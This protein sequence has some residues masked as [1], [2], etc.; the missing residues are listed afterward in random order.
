MVYPFYTALLMF[1]LILCVKMLTFTHDSTPV[2]KDSVDY[3]QQINWAYCGVGEDKDVDVF[4][5]APTVTSG[6]DGTMNMSMSDANTKKSFLGATNMEKGIYDVSCRFYAPYYRQASLKAYQLTEDAREE[7]LEIAYKDVSK[8]FLYYMDNLNNGRPYVLA[9][10]SQGADMCIRLMKDY[11]SNEEY[12]NNLVATYAIGWGLSENEVRTYEWLNPAQ[13]E[14]DLGVIILLNAETPEITKTLS[15]QE[16][17]YGINPL[18]WRTD[19]KIAD[20]SL[21][22]GACFTNYEGE[23]SKEIPNFC[24]CYLDTD[25]GTL[26][27]PDVSTKDYPAGLEIFND[28]DFHIYDYMFFYRNLQDNV[29]VRVNRFISTKDLDLAA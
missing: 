12:M 25:R 20:A 23:I 2:S 21:N 28:G 10:F 19:D 5:I 7:Y 11:F 16:K 8:A 14:D 18:N 24:G 17:T 26:K 15:V 6:S 9:G 22:K 13:S 1:F 29:N 27:L 3:S 4:F